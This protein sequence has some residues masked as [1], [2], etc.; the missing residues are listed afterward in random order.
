VGQRRQSRGRERQHD[1]ARPQ[2]HQIGDGI[3]KK[4][5]EEIRWRNILLK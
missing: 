3:K 2:L 5:G 4:P 1:A